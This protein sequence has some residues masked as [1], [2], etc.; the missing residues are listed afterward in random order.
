MALLFGEEGPISYANF[1]TVKAEG[2][3]S[4]QKSDEK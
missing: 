4:K 1:I 3:G 2:G